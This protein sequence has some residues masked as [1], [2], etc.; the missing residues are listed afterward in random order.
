VHLNSMQPHTRHDE[1]FRR[2]P[3]GAPS[4]SQ[5]VTLPGMRCRVRAAGLAEAAQQSR[6]LVLDG[7]LL[8]QYLSLPQ[9]LQTQVCE[10]LCLLACIFVWVQWARDS[11]C[12]TV[13]CVRVMRCVLCIQRIP[14]S[15]RAS[16]DSLTCRVWVRVR[17]GEDEGDMT[18]G[19]V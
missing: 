8:L 12:A 14:A 5:R 9:H 1:I 7:D 17:V 13:S 15:M 6:L 19:R 18:P 10:Y 2:S 16:C 4:F 3:L 11:T